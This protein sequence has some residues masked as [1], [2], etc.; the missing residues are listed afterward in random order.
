MIPKLVLH[1]G[2]NKTGSSALQATMASNYDILIENG[3]LYPKA[4]RDS[5]YKAAHHP[6]ATA[7]LQNDIS[8]IEM[9]INDVLKEISDTSCQICVLSS[10]AFWPGSEDVPLWPILQQFKDVTIIAYIRESLSYYSSWWQQ[11]IVQIG[12]TSGFEEFVYFQRFAPLILPISRL[13]A[14]E[15]QETKVLFK[16]Y[17][18]QSLIDCDIVADMFHAMS[19]NDK[20]M[21]NELIRDFEQ[22]PSI[23]GNLLYLRLQMAIASNK[24]RNQDLSN[25]FWAISDMAPHRFQGPVS[26]PY[27]K[28][29]TLEWFDSIN[30]GV[31]NLCGL[32]FEM[33]L[34]KDTS[35][36]FPDLATLTE[37][38]ALFS[39]W[40]F[41][42]DI[43]MLNEL[44]CCG[45]FV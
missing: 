19:I 20:V 5:E 27:L 34:D 39:D 40:F 22:N 23:S 7:L 36:H 13:Q 21:A 38:H 30:R 44:R 26:H 6:L 15:S 35:R 11:N 18:R 37:D 41:N 2:S 24:F 25:M 16:N 1:V 3:I 31:N 9:F 32:E 17:S 45:I 4:A 10:E 28:D 14:Y 12:N 33:K 43:N 29:E 42:N 8:T